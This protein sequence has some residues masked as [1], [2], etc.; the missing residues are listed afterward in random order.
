MYQTTFFFILGLMMLSSSAQAN[1]LWFR[2]TGTHNSEN[3]LN[4]KVRLSPGQR[5][6]YLGGSERYQFILGSL[7][8]NTV[9]LQ[10][11]DSWGPSR[12]Y[13]MAV[14]NSPA[15]FVEVSVWKREHL[16]EVRCTLLK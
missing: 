4:T 13:A 1:D 8:N 2:C 3:I 7:G 16:M 9:E 5:T 6:L 11:Y 10:A 14:V 12:S 15:S